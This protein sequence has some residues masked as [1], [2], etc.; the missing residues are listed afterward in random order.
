MTCFNRGDLVGYRLWLHRV[1]RAG[2][3]EAA[4]EARRFEM[5][6][7]HAAALEIGRSRPER[8]YDSFW[9]GNRRASR[10]T[11]YHPP[12]PFRPRAIIRPSMFEIGRLRSD[13]FC[14]SGQAIRS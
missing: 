8:P 13:R 11:K 5:R 9:R 1:A 7:P 4:I 12:N 6:L 10:P 3:E 2:D 14:R